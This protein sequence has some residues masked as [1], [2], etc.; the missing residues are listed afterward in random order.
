MLNAE[1]VRAHCNGC[2]G[3]RNHSVLHRE[4]TI[5]ED[6][7]S[8]ASGKDEYEMLRCMG[9]ERICL[10]HRSWQDSDPEPSMHY[11][12][13]AT[14]RQK[15]AWLEMWLFDQPFDEVVDGSSQ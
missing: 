6:E 15:P 5:W 14:F 1:A 3:D 12:P 13:P 11:F 2:G 8:G 4:S 10:R 9:C 7:Q